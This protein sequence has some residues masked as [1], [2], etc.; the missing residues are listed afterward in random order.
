MELYKD[1]RQQLCDYFNL[2]LRF[3][4]YVERTRPEELDVHQSYKSSRLVLETAKMH[5]LNKFNLKKMCSEEEEEVSVIL[6]NLN[7]LNIRINMNN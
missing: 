5:S 2:N 6:F 4:I 1:I 3:H 7:Y